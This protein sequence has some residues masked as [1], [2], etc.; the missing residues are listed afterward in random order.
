MQGKY[1]LFA[2][3]IRVH[4]S[5]IQWVQITK[6]KLGCWW[7]GEVGGE[8]FMPLYMCHFTYS[9]MMFLAEKN[10]LCRSNRGTA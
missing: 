5:T 3:G 1:L 4:D 10:F 9:N 7:R 2:Q 8:V 6:K